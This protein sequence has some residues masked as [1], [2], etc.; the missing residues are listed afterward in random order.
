M[1]VL[2]QQLLCSM[3]FP[4]FPIVMVSYKQIKGVI[5]LLPH[6]A[7][8][9]TVAE[10]YNLYRNDFPTHLFQSLQN[11]DI[12]IANKRIL[13]L[14]C[15]TGVLSRFLQNSGA[16]VVGVDASKELL[17]Q[18][19]KHQ[20]QIKYLQ[21]TA[22]QIPMDDASFDMVTIL[23]A[24]HWFDPVQASK[25]IARVLKPNGQLLI[26]NTGI[27]PHP[28]LEQTLEIASDY[29][30][31]EE[32]R[33][34]IPSLFSFPIHS[35]EEL[36][37]QRLETFLAWQTEYEVSFDVNTWIGRVSTLSWYSNLDDSQRTELQ[38]R[39]YSKFSSY[40]SFALPHFFRFVSLQK[41]S[42]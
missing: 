4:T 40:S 36:Q 5:R 8:F 39:L 21:G 18:A 2:T 17:E 15:G 14:A 37:Q 23:R 11:F 9:G 32:I 10:Q 35:L 38:K 1:Q 19:K 13:D 34:P 31:K 27:N 20:S 41:K 6:H 33:T 29:I 25:E 12:K 30:P 3:Y 22:E 16:D 28:I 26:I 7:N 24:W 42:I